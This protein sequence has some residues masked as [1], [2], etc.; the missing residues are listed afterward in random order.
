[1]FETTSCT[2]NLQTSLCDVVCGSE[3]CEKICVNENLLLPILLTALNL[4]I[5]EIFLEFG[6]ATKIPALTPQ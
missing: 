6:G 4:N 5:W 1:V 3:T 2:E